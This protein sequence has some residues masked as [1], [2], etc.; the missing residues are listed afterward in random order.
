MEVRDEVCGMTL[1]AENAAGRV[2]HSGRAFFFCSDGCQSLFQED[3]D[4]YA[5]I[6]RQRENPGG[7]HHRHL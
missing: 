3:P 4:R 5:A 7:R 6:A 1:R 2:E